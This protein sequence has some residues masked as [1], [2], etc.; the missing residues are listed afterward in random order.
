MNNLQLST[1]HSIPLVE[2]TGAQAVP[3]FHHESV[4][5]HATMSANDSCRFD[6]EIDNARIHAD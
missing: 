1:V 6:T 5:S 2:R 3:L 4:L